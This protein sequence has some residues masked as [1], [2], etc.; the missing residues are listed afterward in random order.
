MEMRLLLAKIIYRFDMNLVNKD[1]DWDR[2]TLTET[3]W[4]KPDLLVTFAERDMN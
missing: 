3:F 4:K 2:D 1:L